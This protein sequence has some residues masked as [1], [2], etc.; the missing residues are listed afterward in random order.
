[1]IGRYQV[2]SKIGGG[3]MGEVYQARDTG[4]KRDVA[5]KVLPQT[6]AYDPEMQARFTHEARILASLNHPNI[7]AIYDL[8]QFSEGRCLVLEFIEGETLGDRLKRGPLPVAEAIPIFHQI[9]IA[10]EAAH[11]EDVIH[12]DLKPDNIKITPAGM[13]KVLDFGIAKILKDSP[14]TIDLSQ[15]AWLSAT[16]KEE[17]LITNDGKVIGTAPYMSPEHTRGKRVDRRTDLWAF[18]CVFYQALSG[19]LPFDGESIADVVVA[20]HNR[21]PDWLSLPETV[22]ASVSELLRRCLQKNA[23]LRPKSA[24]E[25][26]GSLERWLKSNDGRT[27]VIRVPQQPPSPSPSPFKKILAIAAM[28]IVLA[29]AICFAYLYGAKPELPQRKHLVILPFNSPGG[30]PVFGE[31]L[32]RDLSGILAGVSG[33]QVITARVSVPGS[34]QAWIAERLSASLIPESDDSHLAGRLGASLILRGTARRAADRLHIDY[35]LLDTR[36]RPIKLGAV[37]GA[38]A[39][40]ALDQV[41][42][43][44]TDSLGLDYTPWRAGNSEVLKP[45]LQERYIVALGKLKDDSNEQAVTEAIQLLGEIVSAPGGAQAI[46]YATLARAYL[47]KYYLTNDQLWFG[48]AKNTCDRA[49]TLDPGSY[50]V[51]VALGYVNAELG[52]FAEAINN[53]QQALKQRT[54]YIDAKLG[55]ATAYAGDARSKKHDEAEQGNSQAERVYREAIALSPNYWISYSEFGHF[56][57]ARGLFNQ[58]AEQWQ[59]VVRLSPRN[60]LGYT[61]LGNAFFY[62][63]QFD[64]AVSSYRQSLSLTATPEGYGSLGAALYFQGKYQEAIEEFEKGLKLRPDEPIL[65][66]NL[67][68]AYRQTSDFAKAAEAHDKAIAYWNQRLIIGGDGRPVDALGAAKL[69]DC[70]AKRGRAEESAKQ[71]KLALSIEDK[72]PECLYS[73]VIVYTIIGD[74]DEA[75]KCLKRAVKN[76]YNVTLLENDPELA[77][78]R[79]NPKF[80]QII[81]Q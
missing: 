19:R 71:I 21:E 32:A 81:R 24:K 13:I 58:A 30:D 1:M 9:A 23:D 28:V 12:R 56:Y 42:K 37:I 27:Q 5:L 77:S 8:E 52:R 18:G 4:L 80:E 59:E 55:L 34:D 20:I 79:A 70:L 29:I 47:I 72:N 57:Y 36:I 10:L 22:P 38:D 46:Y 63:G 78:L 74:T 26:C 48:Q 76:G 50:Q 65:W 49:Q 66:G 51:Q 73:A 68:D 17:T 16:T 39:F 40:N 44:V 25:L 31:G 11:R 60:D 7:A 41:A 33:L 64:A 2:L 3:G 69:A 67:G 35:E 43:Q 54:D 62:R 6:Y 53:F 45:D 15:S 75:L 61:N 14:A